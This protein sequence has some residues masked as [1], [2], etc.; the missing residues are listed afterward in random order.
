MRIVVGTP[1]RVRPEAPTAGWHPPCV[2][3]APMT[4]RRFWSRYTHE[5]SLLRARS[6]RDAAAVELAVA[7][8]LALALALPLL[9]GCAHRAAAPRVVSVDGQEVELT[10]ATTGSALAGDAVP[11]G[12]PLLLRLETPIGTATSRIGDPFEATV[13]DD[14]RM[15]R[16]H[17]TVGY[18]GGTSQPTLALDFQTVATAWGVRPLAVAIDRADALTVHVPAPA[19]DRARGLG[20]TH[21]PGQATFTAGIGD[22]V[23]PRFLDRRVT[24]GEVQELGVEHVQLPVGALLRVTLTRPIAR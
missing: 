5:P 1:P 10:A 6:V 19:R 12:T 9:G 23:E 15:T 24:S 17:G 20:P 16:V 7:V 22:T 8:A 18:I 3:C 13:L 14:P 4:S 11:R 2:L 21:P